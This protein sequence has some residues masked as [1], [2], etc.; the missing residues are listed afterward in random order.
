MIKQ[1]E[2]ARQAARRMADVSEADLKR[3][4]EASD[5]LKRQLDGSERRVREAVRTLRRAG[6]LR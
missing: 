2:A 3:A 1:I 5:T 6:L 4:S